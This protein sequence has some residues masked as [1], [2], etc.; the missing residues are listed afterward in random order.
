MFALKKL[1]AYKILQ[2]LYVND[3][4][5]PFDMREE[6]KKLHGT[7]IPTLWPVW[8]GNAYRTRDI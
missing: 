8:I 5:F 1:T 3:G 7:N 2:C 4:E 6:L